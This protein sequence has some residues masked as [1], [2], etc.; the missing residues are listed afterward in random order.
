MIEIAVHI[1]AEH[2]VHHPAPAGLFLPQSIGFILDAKRRHHRPRIGAAQMIALPTA[3]IAENLVTP[4]LVT[5][6]G[7]LGS[8]FADRGIPI[9]R[10][11]APIGAATQGGCQS[12]T[13][14]NMIIELQGLVAGIAA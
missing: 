12:I 2:A 7:E 3:A 4:M 8:D 14:M 5:D 13:A 1:A 6:R 10:F 11:K 9:N